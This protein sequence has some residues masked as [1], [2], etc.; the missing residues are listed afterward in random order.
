MAAQQ[1]LFTQLPSV[2]DLLQQRNKR[3][4]DLQQQLMANAAQGARDP[5]KAQAISFLGSSLGRA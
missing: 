5:A 2:D 1:G 4:T 3:A